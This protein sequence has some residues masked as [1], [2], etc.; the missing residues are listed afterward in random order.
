[1]QLEHTT[2]VNKAWAVIILLALLSVA[3]H[4][5]LAACFLTNVLGFGYPAYRSLTALQTVDDKDDVQW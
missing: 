5:N 4:Y 3:I 2:K 1:M